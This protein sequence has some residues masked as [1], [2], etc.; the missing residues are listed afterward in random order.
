MN[1]KK[2]S[3]NTAMCF[4]KE[5]QTQKEVVFIRPKDKWYG[6]EKQEFCND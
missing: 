1:T 6:T 5:K 4:L 2:I 3:N